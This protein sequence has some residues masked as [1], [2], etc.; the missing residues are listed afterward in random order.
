M[1]ARI[2]DRQTTPTERQVIFSPGTPGGEGTKRY[3]IVAVYVYTYEG[4]RPRVII[5]PSGDVYT[6]D[7]AREHA[8]LLLAAANW[9]DEHVGVT[10]D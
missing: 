1:K 8:A 7:A 2:D 4:E 9:I 6:A 10:N 5:R 3:I